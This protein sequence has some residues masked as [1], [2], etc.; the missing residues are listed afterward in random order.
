MSN[1]N[2]YAYTSPQSPPQPA[3]PAAGAPQPWQIGEVIGHAWNMFKPSWPTLVLTQLLSGL[4]SG[5]P[6]Y[7]PG[8]LVATRAVE[9]HSTEYWTIYSV[10]VFIGL[11]VAAFFTGGMVKVWCSAARGQTPQF[12]DMFAGGSRFLPLLAVLFL[13]LLAVLLG[14]VLLIVPGIIIGLGV[15]FAQFYV[16]DQ[17]MGPI[18][19]MKASWKATKGHKGNIFLFGLVSM[20]IAFAGYAACCVGGLVSVPLV[21]VAFATVYTRLSGTAARFDDAPPPPQ[22]G[23]GYYGSPGGF[24]GPPGYGPPPG[25]FGGYG[26]PPP[27]GFGGPPR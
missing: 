14:Y 24:G 2:P 22:G 5:I 6:N 19:A 20:L 1:Y 9:M 16:V 21:M 27:G 11:V 13:T 23:Y 4:L 12:G 26:G 25:G 3:R 10:C 17:N 15:A 8:I 7:V 18:D